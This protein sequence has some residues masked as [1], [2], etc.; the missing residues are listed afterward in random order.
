MMQI[1]QSDPRFMDVFSV[2]TG[3]DLMNMQNQNMG[4]QEN[5]EERSKQ[6]E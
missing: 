2:T 1:M 3:I 5:H 4:Q 6:F